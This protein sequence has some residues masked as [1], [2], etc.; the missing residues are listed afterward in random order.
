[1]NKAYLGEGYALIMA[2]QKDSINYPD[3]L[4]VTLAKIDN[5]SVTATYTLQ[6]DTTVPR[7]P[8]VFHNPYQ[9]LYKLSGQQLALNSQYKL[10]IRN[11]VSGVEAT[12][13]SGLLG[14]CVMDEPDSLDKFNFTSALYPSVQLVPAARGKIY[15]IYLRFHYM[16]TDNTS[17]ITTAKYF[18][19]KFYDQVVDPSTVTQVRYVVPGPEFYYQVGQ[20][21]PIDANVVRQVGNPAVANGWPIEIFVT[22][23]SEDLYRYMQL[24]SP[25]TTVVQ[26][27]PL[28]SN[29]QNGVGLFTGR[30]DY[31]TYRD[32]TANSKAALDTSRYTKDLNFQ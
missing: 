23:G 3:I 15:N 9:V 8:G 20:H 26:E 22:A 5:G 24:S 12:S 7:D 28:F 17:G 14:N 21:I 10:K 2:E 16:E 4:E 6:Y 19:W 31:S 25:A 11:T 30:L 13:Q 29:I 1:V 18:D 32:I 27:R